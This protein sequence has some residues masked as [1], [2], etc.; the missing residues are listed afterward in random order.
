MLEKRTFL[1]DQGTGWQVALHRYRDPRALRSDTDPVV[2]VPGFAMNSFILGYHPTG[3]PLTA[4]LA[5]RGYEV[6]C[7]DLRGQGEAR[8]VTGSRR[9]GLE[10]VAL[11]D[12]PVAVDAVL[13]RATHAAEAGV[14]LVGCSLGATYMFMNAA[15]RPHPRIARLVNLGGPLRWDAV[16]PLLTL[17]SRAPIGAFPIRGTRRLARAALPLLAK[18]PGVLDLYLNP[19]LCDLT[20]P[21]ALVNTIDDPI[22]RINRQIA[23]WVQARDLVIEGRNLSVDAAN[24]RLPLLTIVANADGIVPEATVTS[25]D[26]LVSTPPALRRVVVAGDARTRM[27]HADLFMSNVAEANVFSP[28]ADWLDDALTAPT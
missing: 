13:E 9:F 3:R 18:L 26:R 12:L 15:W 28:L 11:V 25:G 7:V 20:R 14:S 4:Y 6:F 8:A 24:I 19:A 17:L 1:V 23:R 27:A 16:H 22:P 2:I 5:E 21:E 10:D